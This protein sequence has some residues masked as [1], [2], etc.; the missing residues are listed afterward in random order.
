[1]LLVG[2]NNPPHEVQKT[3]LILLL[4]IMSFN[5]PF[6][7]LFSVV[8]ISNV[9]PFIS[10]SLSSFSVVEVLFNT[11]ENPSL[12]SELLKIKRL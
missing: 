5:I 7:F 8:F 12:T 2:F 4:D 6:I 1:L 3:I 9:S 10:L 11:P